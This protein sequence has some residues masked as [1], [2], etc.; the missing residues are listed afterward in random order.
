TPQEAVIEEEDMS[1]VDDVFFDIKSPT[2]SMSAPDFMKKTELETVPE[3]RDEV[4]VGR[5]TP[6][7]VPGQ[8]HA[9]HH[10]RQGLPST[11]GTA[12]VAVHPLSGVGM[13]RIVGGVMERALD[14]SDR[15]RVGMGI[16]G[17][18]F[19]RSFKRGG[20]DEDVREQI[21]KMHDHRPFFTFWVTFVQIAVYIVS[22]SVYGIA[23]VGFSDTLISDVVLTSNLALEKVAYYEKDNMWIGPR[24]ADLIH[25]GAKYS[26]CM[27]RDR[28]VIAAL[29]TDKSRERETACCIRNAREDGCV[30]KPRRTCSPYL[31]TWWKWGEDGRLGFNNRTNG[32]VCG[33]DPEFCLTPAS[34]EPYVW[35]DDIT[36]WPLCVRTEQNLT[37]GNESEVSLFHPHM[38]C[39][40]RGRPC[41]IGI[42]GECIITTP[43]HC[44]FRKGYYHKEAAL[45]SQ[46]ENVMN[47][48]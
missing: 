30:Q 36:K 33:Q 12:A 11:P 24:Q 10:P 41:C 40:I 18:I 32:S 14:N 17:R 48:G 15:R 25:L 2:F 31:S 19:K 35:P 1:L 9:G 7:I 13:R 44:A 29:E 3:A 4:D 20:V 39:E 23:P 37:H 16:I 8:W 27:R 46:V 45:C 6:K 43:E 42:Q 21:D 22:V 34:T 26:P 38:T 28:N 47:P 5:S